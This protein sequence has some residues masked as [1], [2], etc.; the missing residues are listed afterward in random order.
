MESN[1]YTLFE[2]EHTTGVPSLSINNNFALDK[3]DFTHKLSTPHI[4]ENAEEVYT[5]LKS[6]RNYGLSSHK[7]DL[8]NEGNT[9]KSVLIYK[10]SK[11]LSIIGSYKVK[12]SD[13]M[14]IIEYLLHTYAI[15]YSKNIHE[16]YNYEVVLENTKPD[17]DG[18]WNTLTNLTRNNL[19]EDNFPKTSKCV[20][21]LS[22]FS[23]RKGHSKYIKKNFLKKIDSHF[24]KLCTCHTSVMEHNNPDSSY[25]TS[26]RTSTEIAR[27]IEKILTEYKTMNK[28]KKLDH[29]LDVATIFDKNYDLS[30]DVLYEVIKQHG[31]RFIQRS[32]YSTV[33]NAIG[34]CTRGINPNV[35]AK[36]NESS[37]RIKKFIDTIQQFSLDTGDE[38]N[39]F[40]RYNDYFGEER[41]C[42][43]RRIAQL[44]RQYTPQ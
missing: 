42:S 5:P 38:T 19:N 14:G 33:K 29:L 37:D 17:S 26:I 8:N 28:H 34:T 13:K 21:M 3:L 24:T 9:Q 11:L 22:N 12:F 27:F 32:L 44:R 43:A 23:K 20:T 40:Y 10:K 25:L 36:L 16:L 35:T 41:R 31:N 4:K 6:E 1:D 39:Y 15:L 2:Y 18:F 30:S 7:Q